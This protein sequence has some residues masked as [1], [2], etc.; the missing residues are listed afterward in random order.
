[1]KD[2]LRDIIKK[3]LQQFDLSEDDIP[4]I[5]IEKPNQP[6]HGDAA[7]NIAMKLASVLKM[8]PRKI[9]EQI[10]E[11]L[12]YDEHKLT[13]VEIAGPGFINFRYAENYLFDELAAILQQG[14]TFGQTTE[15]QGQ[16][17]LVEFVSANPT[18]PLTVGHG[19]NAVLGDTIANLLEWTGA[20]VDREYYF[21]NAGRQMRVLGQSVRARYLQELGRDVELP[22]GGYEGEY[23]KDI[24]QALVDRTRR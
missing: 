14:D 22:E 6:D 4:E 18:G 23:I 11:G 7:S 12:E 24:A 15:Q 16:R 2:Y 13:A 3:S 9:A 5:Q 20:E 1:M 19:R 8:N 21:N 10:V 17:I